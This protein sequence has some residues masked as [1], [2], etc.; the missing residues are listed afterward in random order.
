MAGRFHIL[1][2][3]TGSG[4]GGGFSLGPAQ[5]TFGTSTTA[6]ESAAPDV[7]QHLRHRERS[8]AH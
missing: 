8:L 7:T 4:G 2:E 5:N 1:D 3:A 6:S